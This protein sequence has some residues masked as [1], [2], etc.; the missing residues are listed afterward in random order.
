M[1]YNGKRLSD[2]MNVA[3]LLWPCAWRQINAF[4]YAVVGSGP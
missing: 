4:R 1:R 2:A 3:R